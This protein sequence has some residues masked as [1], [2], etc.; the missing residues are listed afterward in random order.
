MIRFIWQN[1]WRRKERFL[2]L[3]VGAFIVSAGLTYL[4]GLSETNKGTV[5][6]N[7]QQR[8]SA[9]Y[10]IVVR[11]DGTR[12]FTEE[13]KLLEPNY[14]SG[15][16]G[17]ISLEQYEAI[18]D[19]PGIEVAAPIAMI[20]YADYEVN[21]GYAD[22]P[23]DGIYRRIMET[24]VDNG[25]DKE[26]DAYNYYFV[27]DVWD[28]MNMGTE[29]G[30]GSPH[31]DL[32]VHSYALLAGID[33]EQEAKLVGLDEAI[34]PLGTSRYFNESDGYYFNGINGGHHE[35]PIIVNQQTF[36]D[37]VESITFE[38]LNIPINQENVY[39][40]METVKEKGGGEYLDS[41][42]GEVV[43]TFTYTGEEAFREFINEK[44]GV[45]W[46]TGEALP[47][48][49]DKSEGESKEIVGNSGED[50][51]TGMVYKPSPL[52]YQE[53]A[54][55]YEDRWPY[56]YQVISFQNGE[57]TVALY[58]NQ[59][60]YREPVLIEEEF[61]NF[62][63][64]NPS[65]IG[66][67]DASELAISKDPTTELPMETYRPATAE[68][69]MDA[70]GN[71]VNPPKQLKPI[72]DPNNFL[73][74]PPGMLTTI[75]AAEK[76]L[77]DK[78]I[79]AIR[80]KVAGVTD[81]SDESQAILEQVAS[82]IENKTG[83]ITDITLGSSPQ[84][85]LTYVSG[86][87]GDNDIGW[88][89]QPW[90]NIGSSIS[91]FKET[92]IGFSGVVASVIAIAIVYVW[93]SGIVNL[94]A[95][96][97]EFAVLLSIGWRPSQLSRLLFLESSI[98]GIFVA[99]ISWIMLGFVYVSSDATISFDR[100][101]WTGLFGLIVYIL[102]SV[103]PII[104]IRNISPYEAMR[105]GEIS[106]TSKRMF[107]AKGINRM[108]FN[109]F[110]GK[111][112]R[113]FLSVISI[114]LPTSLLAVF[115][116]ITF[117]LR[118]IMYTSL[119]G[120]YVALE[121]GPQH[122]VAII[123]SLIIAILTTAEIMWQN[124]SERREEI[125]LLQAIGWK[126]WSIR[127]LILAEGIFSGLVAAVIGL[128]IAFLMMWGLYGAF[129]KEEIGFIVATGL[130][131]VVIGLIGTIFPAERAV[132]IIPNQGIGGN[133]SNRK[134][135][136]RRLKWIVISTSVLLVGTFLFTMVKVAPN[137][138]SA[139]PELEV[140][141][142][143]S[144]T[145]GSVEEDTNVNNTDQNT[146]NNVT[147]TTHETTDE[148]E[149]EF[150]SDETSKNTSWSGMLFYEAKEIESSL[151]PSESGM[152]NIGIEFTFEILDS[153]TYGIRPKQ[154]FTL[155]VGEETYYPVEVEVLEAQGWRDERW[156]EGHRDGMMHAVLEFTVPD[157]TD[158]YGLLL[159]SENGS[160]GRGIMVWFE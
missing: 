74:E 32:T 79:S 103:I 37:K 34:I 70:E 130:I 51:V 38:R 151:P 46:E 98:I 150:R 104:L 30:V 131:P 8:W 43:E 20:G 111:W 36:V 5:V 66:F 72:G 117:R 109:H 116:Y 25:I 9:S 113:S 153:M 139:N 82:E 23:E 106:G 134:A 40:V 85:A 135:V 93:A 83:L 108:A 121:I 145:E 118:G 53:I 112:K 68:F 26:T 64:I 54:S 39:E 160:V 92:K 80:I 50:N 3:I 119:L 157:N 11:P 1:W 89:Q 99:F 102:G 49:N 100:F 81:L 127:R 33:P 78:P 45:D 76:I 87:N 159:K 84:L 2:L 144:P 86:L 155:L 52:E 91:I 97:K 88:L 35:F 42:E 110:I 67:Y 47:I 132:R 12:S 146:N 71:P 143:F 124:V 44:T 6:D 149:L 129:P 158:S 90:V 105:T 21:F 57:D 24:T 148:Y 125:S 147:G 94:L 128:T 14:L 28:N 61:I 133:I 60:S 73:T 65:W 141:Q 122:Y 95:R 69:V 4:I 123:I 55:P 62:P 17:G 120:E 59:E 16:S 137:I 63:R 115:L 19:I 156:L 18:K 75:E 56:T 10:D 29:Y 77:G 154:H 114:A 138:E 140:E 58:R 15:L 41:I 126:R 22:L 13:K 48:D 7:L 136:E 96:R 142:A 107:Q 101:L 27:S 31:P 152:Q